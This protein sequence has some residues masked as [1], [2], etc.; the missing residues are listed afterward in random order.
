MTPR[1]KR[2][3]CRVPVALFWRRSFKQANVPKAERGFARDACFVCWWLCLRCYHSVMSCLRRSSLLS[4]SCRAPLLYLPPHGTAPA[5]FM[6]FRTRI[7]FPMSEWAFIKKNCN[8]LKYI[9]YAFF[10]KKIVYP[11]KNTLFIKID[12]ISFLMLMMLASLRHIF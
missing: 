3:P 1:A 8:P 7:F 11:S 12:C 6:C 2:R 10:L 4:L 9:D 5:F